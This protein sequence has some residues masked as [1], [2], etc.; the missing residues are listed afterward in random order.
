MNGKVVLLCDNSPSALILPG[1]F[2]G[3]MESSEDWY[4][5]FEMASFL[6]ILRYL[7]LLTAMLLPGLYLAVIRFHTQILPANLLLSFAEARE[8]VPF[9]S[10]T[11][12]ILLELAFELIRE[13]GVRVP[14]AL[15]NAIGIVGGLIIGDAA[16]TLINPSFILLSL[17]HSDFDSRAA[18]QN[19]SQFWNICRY[20]TIQ[21]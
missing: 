11:E 4:H 13:A 10:V 15:G 1:S 9:T 21:S 16:A 12:L 18:A 7:A 3:F 2:S 19:F 17:L 20:T 5:H 14:G 6:R 8:G